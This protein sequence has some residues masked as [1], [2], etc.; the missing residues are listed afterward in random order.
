LNLSTE[1]NFAKDKNDSSESKAQS[2]ILLREKLRKGGVLRSSAWVEAEIIF[3]KLS[4]SFLNSEIE[5]VQV[6]VYGKYNEIVN[7]VSHVVIDTE[8]WD[9]K[10]T[11][12]LE[13]NFPNG[14]SYFGSFRLE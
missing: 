10:I 7:N 12:Y 14:K 4:I 13:I 11:Y 1:I 2:K 9:P 8:N 3:R 6:I 5:G